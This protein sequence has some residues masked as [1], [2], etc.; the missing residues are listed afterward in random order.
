MLPKLEKH[1][2]ILATLVASL[3][4]TAC[5]AKKEVMS[6]P[7][8]VSAETMEVKSS[9]SSDQDLPNP[10]EEAPT[11]SIDEKGNS[12]PP[13]VFDV[14]P[15]EQGEFN[16]IPSD[17]SQDRW[18]DLDRDYSK[19]LTGAITDDGLLYTSSSTDDIHAYL[20]ARNERVSWAT[21]QANLAAAA[22]IESAKIATDTLSGD[23]II[24][25]KIREGRST[26][27]YVVAGS[28]NTWDGRATR[29]K[30]VRASGSER[31]TG[32]AEI[33]GT[34]KCLDLDGGCETAFARLTVGSKGSSAVVNVIFRDSLADLHIGTPRERSGNPEF[35]YL[36]DYFMMTLQ[37]QNTR[38]KI[39]SIDMRSWEVV[40]GRSGVAL[41]VKG[42]NN[43]LLGFAGPL[44]APEA[45][46][47]VNIR[48]A[49]LAKDSDESLDLIN[50]NN[51][52]L[53]YAN[54]IGEA[55]MVANNSL[56][57]MKLVLKM[58][59]RGNYNQ[60]R[61]SLTFMRKVK[62]IVE[63]TDANLELP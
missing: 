2:L 62:P 59:K 47:G 32:S 8:D 19:K 17:Y 42:Y 7:K 54:S 5:G 9:G 6:G 45:G 26:Q 13:P 3:S 52:K 30:K 43:E 25:L 49:R 12:L 33:S 46:T 23:A 28:L 41:L 24:T 60:D 58:R 63:L 57:Q 27:T 40:N 39:K 37:R 34:L 31:T 53:N 55:R 20:R 1:M 29:V 15:V 10:F 4:L 21:K 36:R 35:E 51:V 16:R 22:S 44:L 48:M 56:G 14:K 11:N 61:F 38:E 50:T 18:Y